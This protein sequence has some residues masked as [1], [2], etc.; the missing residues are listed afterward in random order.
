MSGKRTPIWKIMAT[1]GAVFLI[2]TPLFAYLWGTLNELLSGFFD[3][4][5]LIGAVPALLAFVLLLNYFARRI[6]EWE[7]TTLD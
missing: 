6:E 2:G 1:L 7:K 5:L 3:P 4:I